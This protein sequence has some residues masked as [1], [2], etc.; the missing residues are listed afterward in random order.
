LVDSVVAHA[1]LEAASASAGEVLLAGG[2]PFVVLAEA[3][4]VRDFVPDLA[5][6]GALPGGHLLVSAPGDQGFD[7]VT[8]VFAPGV[9]IPEDP[10]TG[11][12]HCA[13][14]AYWCER[15][16]KDSITAFQASARGGYFT[17]IW[18]REEGR[19]DLIGSCSTFSRGEIEL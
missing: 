13:F 4:D 15:L 5:A 19:V 17:C 10:A 3:S 9:G 14:A 1:A 2:Y 7:A 16:G 8:R 11:S 18:R 12:A 6:I